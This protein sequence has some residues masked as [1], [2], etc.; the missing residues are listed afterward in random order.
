V[1]LEDIVGF[2]KE[3]DTLRIEPCVPESWPEL[4][5]DYRFGRTTYAIVVLQPGLIRTRGAIVTLDDVVLGSGVI[6]LRD[7]GQRH[8][9]RC[10]PR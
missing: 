6:P 3:G 5:V 2:K 9:V 10:A 1:G 8:E 4:R 7:D